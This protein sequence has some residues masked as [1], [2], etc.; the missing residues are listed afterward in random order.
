ME[1]S[2]MPW[3]H[4]PGSPG[5]TSPATQAEPSPSRLATVLPLPC[6][7]IYRSQWLTQAPA[8]LGPVGPWALVAAK[9]HRDSLGPPAPRSVSESLGLGVGHPGVAP[10][11]NKTVTLEQSRQRWH[12][13]PLIWLGSWPEGT[14]TASSQGIAGTWA[15]LAWPS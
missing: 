15:G 12:A 7:A 6:P 9:S 14:T 3:S 4:G 5:V 2:L 10:H 11:W 1:G 8:Q 13:K